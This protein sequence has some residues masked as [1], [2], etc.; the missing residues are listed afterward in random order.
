MKKFLKIFLWI[1]VLAVFAGT[2]VFLY[3]NSQPEKET[4]EVVSP[5]ITTIERST[6][7]TG[8]IE[9]RDEI[10][11]KP[12]IS[13][14]ISEINV[15]A[16]DFVNE[17]DV[18]AKIKVIPDDSQLS[19]AR[20]RV[21]VAQLSLNQAQS[22]YKRTKQ[23]YEKKFVSREEYEQTETEY[24]KAQ[25]EL[26]AAEDALSIV[27]DGVSK[28]NAQGSN[29]LVRATITGQVLEVPVKVGSSVIQANTMNDG[30]TVVKI[31]DMNNL[32]F[33]GKVDETE[34]GLLSQGMPLTISVGAL[35][36]VSFPGVIEYL[37]PKSTEEN[38]SNTFELK[39]AITVTDSVQLRAGYS[40]NAEVLLQQAK[41]V[42]TVPEGVVEWVGDSTY[43]Y[44]LT[45]ETPEQTFDRQA[46][47]TGI[48]DGVNIHV[49]H[50]LDPDVRL[51]GNKIEKQ[52]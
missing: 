9:P 34:V 47:R 30:T 36:D 26:M 44:V 35:P 10:E 45:S 51:R 37:S 3:R 16:G 41:D 33:I 14:I 43:V 52:K 46:V 25:K 4:F 11:V 50:G 42:L 6:V 5:S 17:G 8:K 32:L 27:K 39:G 13:G 20:N 31:A 15:E 49:I 7:L 12:Q 18:V 48:S 28:Y 23:L 2:F 21:E 22:V 24:L 29:T 38:G 1:V 19:S 40:A